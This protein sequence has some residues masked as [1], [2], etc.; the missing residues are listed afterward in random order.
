MVNLERIK[1]K[2]FEIDDL[3]YSYNNNLIDDYSNIGIIGNNKMILSDI[4]Y[5]E[6]NIQKGK[7]GFWVNKNSF[8]KENIIYVK[9]LI[10]YIEYDTTLNIRINTIVDHI[11]FIKRFIHF[12]NQNSISL[13]VDI[14]YAKEVFELYSFHLSALNRKG[15]NISHNQRFESFALKF[16][17][18]IFNDDKGF[19]SSDT[20]LMKAD[21]G[22]RVNLVPSENSDSIY[23]FTF[24]TKLF[25]QLTDFLLEFNKYPFTVE[26]PSESLCILPLKCWVSP[27]F[28]NSLDIAFS[29]Y[30]GENDYILTSYQRS[31]INDLK[32]KIKI[33]NLKNNTK[34]R[35]ELGRFALKAYFM[36]FLSITGMNDST[37]SNISWNNNFEI[38][39]T[40]QKF[41][42][43]KYRANNKTVFFEIGN[44]YIKEFN[45]FIKLRTFLLQNN[46]V[47][48][49]FFEKYG[50]EAFKS[51][52]QKKGSF[53]N[54][55]NLQM[56]HLVDDKLP[57]IN[58]RELRVNKS[59]YNIKKHGVVKASLMSC[60]SIN[61][62]L[63][64]YTGENIYSAAEQLT[65]YFD[66]ID[67]TLI[68]EEKE[69]FDIPSGR[70]RDVNNP[71]A[72][73]ELNNF[74]INCEQNEGCLFCKQYRIH[75]DKEDASKLYS[76][77]YI[78]NETRYIAKSD[79]H[80]N[81]TYDV[82]IK[83]I[84]T[85]I[86]KISEYLGDEVLLEIE[87]D[88]FNNENL[89]PYWEHKLNMLITIG[90]LI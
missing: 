18:L 32:K 10:E 87:N 67:K 36:H 80:F 37:A 33:N 76:L 9:Y 15:E 84:N 39:K 90:V 11:S 34:A 4:L 51:N 60:N 66:N 68:S 30:Q 58:S 7:N 25:N 54:R 85:I 8:I 3:L 75:P 19:I 28:K 52:T 31:R 41:S 65:N 77:L 42:A 64:H 50:E 44:K 62:T 88:V 73:M 24:F 29:Y 82:I 61:V 21:R 16:L 14:N 45:K 27:T 35:L 49:L 74:S 55:I 46:K 89:H 53:S 12:I 20:I 78:I 81:S 23:A 83:R 2:Y 59:N 57:I 63:N 6:F 40:R 47:E 69:L 48:Y 86:K 26:L 79:E 13:I 1:C 17:I 38:V 72:I 71:K 43:I 22:S 56:K 70:C 5:K